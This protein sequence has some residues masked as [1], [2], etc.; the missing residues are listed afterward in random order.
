[1]NRS[2]LS[3]VFLFVLTL[4]VCLLGCEEK[5]K[6]VEVSD[7]S[8][9]KSEL[10]LLV[11]ESETLIATIAPSDATYKDVTWSSRSNIVTVD[12]NGKVTALRAGTATVIVTT[13]TG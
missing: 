3:K 11:G 1:M 5:E 13:T 7:V 10:T 9:N 12:E 4:S 6:P 8:L 2:T